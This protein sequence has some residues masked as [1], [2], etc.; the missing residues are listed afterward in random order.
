M[1]KIK[2]GKFYR[3]RDGRKVG[4]M[5][6][7]DDDYRHT[8]PFYF[9]GISYTPEGSVSTAN[10]EYE[11]DIIAEWPEG[12]VRTVTRREIV[13]GV[14]GRIKV[15][16]TYHGNRVTLDWDRNDVLAAAVP[17]VGMSADELRSAAM[18]FSQ[19]V[20]AL[21]SNEETK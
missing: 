17:I 19:L 8:Y 7:N 1:L 12:P 11:C 14:Y 10:I 16:G 21:D 6:V 3:T 15:T 18:I 5:E 4:P 13:P 2:E 9:G 20:E